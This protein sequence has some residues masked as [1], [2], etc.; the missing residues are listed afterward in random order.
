MWSLQGEKVPKKNRISDY[1]KYI[2]E[3][4]MLDKCFAFDD[5]SPD[6]FVIHRVIERKMINEMFWAIYQQ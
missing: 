1:N 4:K 6:I 3:N 2:S 5:N